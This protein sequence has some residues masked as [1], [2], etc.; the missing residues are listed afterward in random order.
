MEFIK[1]SKNS[2]YKELSRKHK[3]KVIFIVYRPTTDVTLYIIS[4]KKTI[5]KCIAMSVIIF[6][7]TNGQNEY[8]SDKYA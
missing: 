3:K 2:K 4:T 1:L 6:D 5:R 8:L 7:Q